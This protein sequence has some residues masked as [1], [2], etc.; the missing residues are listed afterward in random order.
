MIW[1]IYGS[2]GW[3]GTMITDLLRSQGEQV[4]E[5]TSRA[6]DHE[7]VSKELSTVNP[8]RVISCVARTHGPGCNTI[9]YCEDHVIENVRDNLV[10]PLVLAI[11]CERKIHDFTGSLGTATTSEPVVCPAQFMMSRA[12]ARLVLH[13]QNT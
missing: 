7:S 5:A 2:K 9:D 13:F 10:S 11:L 4:V 12:T 8:D 6:N 1:L 3:I